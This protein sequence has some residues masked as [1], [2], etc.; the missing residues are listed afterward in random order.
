MAEH[1]VNTSRLESFSD[2]VISIIMT[3]MVFDLKLPVLNKGFLEKSEW[4]ELISLIPG[5]LSYSMSFWM[6]AIMW[7]NHHQLFHQVEHTDRKLLW[8]NLHLLFWMS[9]IP[10]STN[11]IGTNPFL[12]VA[13]LFYGLIFFMNAWSFALL[14]KYVSTDAHLIHKKITKASVSR[15]RKKNQ[16]AMALYFLAMLATV[17]SVYISFLLFLI[18]PLMYSWPDAIEIHDEPNSRDMGTPLDRY[19]P[20]NH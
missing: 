18:V 3:I 20:E 4:E 2:G 9:I 12:P 6:L 1:R 10:Y 19:K 11:F 7:V 14:R 5:F 8:Y 13:S 17:I 16:G 15:A